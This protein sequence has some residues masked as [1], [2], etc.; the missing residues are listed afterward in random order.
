MLLLG[1]NVVHFLQRDWESSFYPTSYGTLYYPEDVPVVETW[2]PLGLKKL[3]LH[4]RWNQ[5]VEGWDLSTNDGP[6]QFL[7]GKDPVIPLVDEDMVHHRYVLTS[8]PAHSAGTIELTIRSIPKSYYDKGGLT[9]FPHEELYTMKTTSP[10]GEFKQYAVS[11]WLD[12][13]TYV[14]EEQLAEIDRILREEVKIT[15]EDSSLVKM[16]KLTIYL[17]DRLEHGRGVPKDD[18]RWKNPCLLLEEMSD[19]TGKGWCT[20]FGQIWTLYANRAGVPTRLLTG[21]VSVNNMQILYTGH[22]WSECYI[23][24]Q[25]RWA[26]VDLSHSHIYVTDKRGQVLNTVELQNLAL[27]D[28][29]DGVQARIYK[30]WEWEHL[31]EGDPDTLVTVPFASCNKVARE[32]F[33]EL[34]IIKFRRPPNVEDVRTLGPLFKDRAFAWGNVERYLFKPALAYA[35]VP[36]DGMQTYH[37]RWVLFYGMLAVLIAWIVSLLARRSS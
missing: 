5:P 11:E 12:D 19:G 33:S 27:H 2:T 37:T 16:E 22:T 32:Q 28:A 21:A 20:Q 8:R 31:P 35:R 13:Y 24:E 26:F 23:E 18:F 29:F 4:V 14:G 6:S 1:A 10:I 15:P 30:D 25:Q 7:P 9:T 3:Q 34:A 36:T 17:R